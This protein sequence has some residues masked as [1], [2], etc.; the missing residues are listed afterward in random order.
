MKRHLRV[1]AALAMCLIGSTG[2][3]SLKASEVN[4]ETSI[5]IDHQVAV[6]G[7]I[8]PPGKYVLKVRDSFNDNV[9]YIFAGDGTRL[10]TAVMAIH[11]YRL[12]PADK[13]QFSFYESPSGQP[14]ALHLW[15]Y[16]GDID[17][18]EFP[19]PE[20]KSAADSGAPGN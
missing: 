16:P 5:T 7:T 8:L 10:I 13:S 1:L 3:P 12:E 4:K 20:R 9:V 14:A 15:F 11:A 18:F 17:G 2:I 19:R 6:R